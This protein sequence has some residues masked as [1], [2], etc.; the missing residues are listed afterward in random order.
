MCWSSLKLVLSKMNIQKEDRSSSCHTGILLT[1]YMPSFVAISSRHFYGVYMSFLG[2]CR[3]L[4][5]KILWELFSGHNSGSPP[6]QR[7]IS[8]QLNNNFLN[9]QNYS[10]SD[11]H[12]PIKRSP[13]CTALHS[14][15]I[16][17]PLKAI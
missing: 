3:H 15:T 2:I 7:F 13:H 12:H 14:T 10:L 5:Q 11:S 8:P 17:L 6:H 16:P 9:G 4:N 1:T